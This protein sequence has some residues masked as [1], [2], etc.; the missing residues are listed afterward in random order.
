MIRQPVRSSER[1]ECFPDWMLRVTRPGID[2]DAA[3]EENRA[4][5][6]GVE[7]GAACDERGRHSND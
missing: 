7:L 3:I 6:E 2:L 4:P 5:H 1:G